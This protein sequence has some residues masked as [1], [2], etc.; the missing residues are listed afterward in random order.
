ML[1][2][3]LALRLDPAYEK[4][5]RRFYENP[6]E[7]ADAFARAWFKLTHRD[8]GPVVRYLGPEVPAEELL[9]QDPL[10]QVDQRADRRRRRGR[11][12]GAD[13]R[14]RSDR[15]PAGLDHLGGG[16]LLPGQRQAGRRQRCPH[17]A[18]AAEGLG[19][20]QP[21]PADRRCWR[22]W[23]ASRPRSTTRQTGGKPVSL[24]DLIVL[25]GN[26]AVEQ[27]AKAAGVEVTCRSTPGRVDATPGADRRRVVRLPG[28][29]RRRVPQLLRQVRTAAGRVPAGRQGQPA[30]PE[31][32]GDD[33]PRRRSAGARGQLGRHFD[34]RPD[35]S[36]R[37][38]DERLL[39]QPAGRSARPGSRWIRGRTPS[40]AETTPPAKPSGSAA[41]PTWCSARTP[42]CGRWPRCTRA[43][44]PRR[45][46]CT[47]SS[48]RGAR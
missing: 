47:T 39:R 24:A 36:A 22:P 8:M 18:G 46:S 26:A 48:R 3:D 1:T 28:A 9:W 45:S 21:G 35:R 12:Q 7:F 37:R 2:T 10:P 29:G 30:H 4:I 33:G 42:S 20:Q 23:R 44:T 31:R 40:R 14:V 11:A 27:A 41:A 25:A 5:S 43:T 19:G 17:S 13:P 32:A 38:L 15:L 34:R 16:V 6:D